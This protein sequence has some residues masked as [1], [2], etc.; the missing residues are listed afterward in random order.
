MKRWWMWRADEQQHSTTFR[1]VTTLRSTYGSTEGENSILKQKGWSILHFSALKKKER[2]ICASLSILFENCEFT[3]A[4]HG[5]LITPNIKPDHHSTSCC[6]RH[7]VCDAALFH[8]S[9]ASGCAWLCKKMLTSA[10][11]CW[12]YTKVSISHQYSSISAKPNQSAAVAEGIG[13]GSAA[14]TRKYKHRHVRRRCPPQVKLV[15]L[16]NLIFT[17]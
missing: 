16:R 2:K 15:N 3:A 10:H 4:T 1:T 17:A 8:P 7:R 5:F 6:W 13:S 11:R 9:K 14:I 12:C